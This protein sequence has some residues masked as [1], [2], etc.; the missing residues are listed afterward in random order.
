MIPFLWLFILL[1]FIA[2]VLGTVGAFGSS[3]FF[4]PVAGY[5]FDFHAVLGITAVFH[6]SSNLVKIGLF[7]KGIDWK[8]VFLIG[9]PAI[10][11][12]S[13]GAFLTSYVDSKPLQ[14]GLGFFLTVTAIFFLLFKSLALKANGVNAV[15]GGAVSGFLAGFL[16]SGGPIRGLTLTAFN[17]RKEIFVATSAFIDLGIDLSR[18]A[19]YFGNGYLKKEHI[20]YILILIIIAVAGTWTG[21]KILEKIPADYF[22]LIVL[23]LILIIG[24]VTLAGALIQFE[25]LA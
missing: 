4:V 25:S 22:R 24:V 18:S 7:R 3:V 17:M 16:G 21:K 9:I 5:F 10:I 20:P 13:A 19:I 6:L 23:F 12:C 1:A 2:E 8:L 15:S 14:I 11:F